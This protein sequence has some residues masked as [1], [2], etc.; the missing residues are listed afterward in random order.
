MKLFFLLHRTSLDDRPCRRF[1]TLELK[2][3]ILSSA[4]PLPVL[5]LQLVLCA[6]FGL[7]S[8]LLSNLCYRRK[9]VDMKMK[10]IIRTQ[11]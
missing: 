8:S 9:V 1:R 11:K 10:R 2:G 5:K 7:F 4:G 6:S 3:Q